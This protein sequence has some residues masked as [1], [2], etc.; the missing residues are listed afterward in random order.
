MTAAGC[1]LTFTGLYFQIVYQ[2]LDNSS[3][4]KPVKTAGLVPQEQLLN[5]TLKVPSIFLK[6]GPE[7]EQPNGGDITPGMVT[8][9]SGQFSDHPFG[10]CGGSSDGSISP[11]FTATFI[12]NIRVVIPKNKGASGILRSN[13]WTQTAPSAPRKGTLTNG[14]DVNLSQ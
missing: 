12:Q 8:D 1:L 14:V 5:H 13:N 11:G 7:D 4:P 10:Q 6:M 9:S 3:P 2:V